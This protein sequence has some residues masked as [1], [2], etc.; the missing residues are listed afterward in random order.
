[1]TSFFYHTVQLISKMPDECEA[2]SIFAG[3]FSDDKLWPVLFQPS[4]SLRQYLSA[5]MLWSHFHSTRNKQFSSDAHLSELRRSL[6]GQ[7]SFVVQSLVAL[8]FVN[9]DWRPRYS[10]PPG[11]ARLVQTS[12]VLWGCAPWFPVFGNLE[13]IASTLQPVRLCARDQRLFSA[14]QALAD[15]S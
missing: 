1:M 13:S 15:R 2:D 8:L 11:A 10:R 6:E 12:H 3:A 7:S 9:L 4:F 14:Q 5:A